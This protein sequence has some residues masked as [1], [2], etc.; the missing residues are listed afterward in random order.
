MS[1]INDIQDEIISEFSF[2][3]D[4]MEK[5]EYIIDL[6]KTLPLIDEQYKDEKHLIKGCQCQVWLH[7]DAAENIEVKCLHPIT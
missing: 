3:G 1:Q 6:G 5:Y 2:F 4:W 7:A